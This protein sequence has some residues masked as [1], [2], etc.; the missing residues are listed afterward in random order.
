VR[1]FGAPQAE[2]SLKYR[3][4]LEHSLAMADFLN[5]P[6]LALVQAMAN[7]VMLS[8]RHDSPRFVWMMT[9]LLIRMAQAIGLHRDGST[10]DLSPFES[11]IR[12][13]VWWA[14][15]AIDIRASEDQGSEFTIS[16][17]SWDTKMPLNINDS[18]LTAEMKELP[19]PRVGYTDMTFSYF[20]YLTHQTT[21][22]MM[23][24]GSRNDNS[25]LE[26]QDR[27]LIE[28][29]EETDKQ[30]L[31]Y[32]N[33]PGS[34]KYWIALIVTRLVICKLTLLVYL[35]SL[36][37]SPNE[38]FSEGVRNKLL[39][40]AIELAEY[41][42][43]LNENEDARSWRWIYQTYT[44]WQ[45]V[46]YLLIESCRRQLSPLMERAWIALHSRWLIPARP[47]D[48][49]THVKIWLPLRGMMLKAR[50]H[51]EA[52]LER[53][54]VASP[55]EIHQLEMSDQ[56]VGVPVSSGPFSAGLMSDEQFLQHWRN[57]IHTPADAGRR[58]KSDSRKTGS[59][60]GESPRQAAHQNDG[61]SPDYGQFGMPPVL[62][63]DSVHQQ[64]MSQ[65]GQQMP[66]QVFMGTTSAVPSTSYGSATPGPNTLMPL[67]TAAG[68][69]SDWSGFTPWLWAEAD[70]GGNMFANI[71]MNMD[72]DEETDWN[73]WLAS[74][75]KIA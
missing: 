68:I 9:G 11:E 49:H 36:F 73:S 7:F 75:S 30:V 29:F 37:E 1:N 69:P 12:R 8:R 32:V 33:E 19:P 55:A 42:H 3:L 43:S 67:G 39:I 59:S 70:T 54:R 6:D 2:L 65:G 48:V 4:G 40:S 20:G 47:E 15:C 27:L 44:H 58:N 18:D 52:E 51:R 10:L 23:A 62:G 21:R 63:E 13:R 14:L 56:K 25:T 35:P 46:V 66:Q 72:I 26:Q 31:Q 60:Q 28:L 41:N 74:A 64:H 24:I 38:R 34:I 61:S 71:D 45:A 50:R 53:L 17:E 16:A 22:K 57:L 5:N